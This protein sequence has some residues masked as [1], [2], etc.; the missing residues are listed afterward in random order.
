MTQSINIVH[1]RGNN[2]TDGYKSFSDVTDHDDGEK[3]EEVRRNKDG[4]RKV[5]VVEVRLEFAVL[6]A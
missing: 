3:G 4:K 5:C 6:E 2:T 1:S